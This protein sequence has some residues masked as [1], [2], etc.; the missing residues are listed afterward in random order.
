MCNEVC[1]CVYMLC[2][3]LCLCLFGVADV[4]LGFAELVFAKQNR[5]HHNDC[6]AEGLT[7]G[8]HSLSQPRCICL[9]AVI[10]M[11]KNPYV[12]INAHAYC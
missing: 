6:P 1:E 7:S 2:V 10:G 5:C 8:R 4:A 9:Q 3:K 12:G 11:R